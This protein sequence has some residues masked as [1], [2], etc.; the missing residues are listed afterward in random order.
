MNADEETTLAK[1][2]GT[3]LG[4]S[5]AAA[6]FTQ[7]QAAEALGIG[8]EAVSRIERGVVI[9][10]LPRLT[11]FAELYNCPVESLLGKAA[12][13]PTGLALTIAGMLGNLGRADRQ[14]VYSLIETS[15]EH[16][17]SRKA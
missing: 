5:R 12:A 13:Q 10:S 6:G 4:Q 15:C 2:V 1:A 8:A 3:A 14:F 17:N 16:L 7:E 11:E 9:P